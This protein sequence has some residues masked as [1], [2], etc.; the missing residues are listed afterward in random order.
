MAGLVR[1][2]GAENF[3]PRNF[4]NFH[5]FLANF[6]GKRL[7]KSLNCHIQISTEAKHKS[8]HD[9]CFQAGIYS[10]MPVLLLIYNSICYKSSEIGVEHILFD[11]SRYN[12]RAADDYQ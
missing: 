12:N 7:Y 5:E 8:L 9:E 6:D 10:E 4:E 1:R 3:R 2:P 11:C